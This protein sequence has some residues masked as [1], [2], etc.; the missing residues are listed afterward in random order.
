MPRPTDARPGVE[1]TR[2]LDPDND[3]MFT[4][5]VPR[6]N[7]R[8]RNIGWRL[9]YVL[10]SESLSAQLA[11]FRI[12]AHVGTSDHTPVMATFLDSPRCG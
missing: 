3:Q 2:A 6:R 9:D 4:R 12:L 10:V 8:Q 11:S 1:P 7:L 5:W